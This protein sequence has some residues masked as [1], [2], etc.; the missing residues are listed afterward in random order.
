MI[1]DRRIIYLLLTACIVIPLIRPLNLP[2]N[3]MPQTQKLFNF[4]DTLKPRNQAVIISGD[5]APGTMPENHPM[6]MALLRHCFARHIRVIMLS[7][8]PQNPSLALD[9]LSEVEIEM[10][11]RAK[12]REDSIIYGRDYI[13]LGWKSG[14]AASIMGMG[15]AISLV[16]PKD[17]YQNLTDTLLMMREIRNY[18]QVAIAISLAGAAYPESWMLYGQSRYGLKVAAGVTAVMAAD[19][20]TFLQTGQFIGML[21]GM[22]GAAEYEVLNERF[23]YSK[24]FKRANQAMDSQSLVHI[25]I[26]LTI[27]VGNIFFFIERRK[28]R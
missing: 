14:I 24:A 3:I 22:K 1:I 18:K 5:Y 6:A 8:D 28:K 11:K 13:Y 17:Y 16:Y 4:I 26:I 20:Y 25:L 12:S 10:N 21:A 9:A 23:G 27:I 15:E 19:Y 2:Q 7:L